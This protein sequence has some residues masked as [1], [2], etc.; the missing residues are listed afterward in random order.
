MRLNRSTPVRRG[1]DLFPASIPSRVKTG[2]SAGAASKTPAKTERQAEAEESTAG[3]ITIDQF[4]QVDLRVAKILTAEAVPGTDRLLRLTVDLGALGRRQV[5]AGIARAYSPDELAGH[6][7][8]FVANL[9]PAKLRGILSGVL[10][11]KD[12]EAWLYRGSGMAPG[13]KVS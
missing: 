13:S 12:E 7:I 8:L 1:D 2:R 3:L 4:Q 11:A 10:L 9:K 5:V 6:L